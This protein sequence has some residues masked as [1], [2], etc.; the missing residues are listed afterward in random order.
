MP[1]E[2]VE[3][4]YSGDAWVKTRVCTKCGSYLINEITES[5]VRRADER[6]IHLLL[7]ENLIT[8]QEASQILGL[9]E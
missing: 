7:E 9:E 5:D 4:N 6:Y 2:A 3:D 8:R 1:L